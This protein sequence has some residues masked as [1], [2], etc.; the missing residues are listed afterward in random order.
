MDLAQRA[1]AVCFQP[2][3]NARAVKLV[4]AGQHAQDLA[5][6]VAVQADGAALRHRTVHARVRV[7]GAGHVRALG[8]RVLVL[9][10]SQLCDHAFGQVGHRQLPRNP[11]KTNQF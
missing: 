8:A 4:I 10:G 6:V 11:T 1:R 5:F 2:G 9:P 7:G 3:V